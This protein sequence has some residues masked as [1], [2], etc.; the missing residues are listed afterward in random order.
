MLQTMFENIRKVD[1]FSLIPDC[2]MQNANRPETHL[3]KNTNDGFFSRRD[4]RKEKN[5]QLGCCLLVL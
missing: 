5:K 1:A 3:F 4:E 2:E